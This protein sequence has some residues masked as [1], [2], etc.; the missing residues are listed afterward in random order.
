MK[1]DE[2]QAWFDAVSELLFREPPPSWFY[3]VAGIF[4][5]VTCLVI[6]F[7]SLVGAWGK[8]RTGYIS[9]IKP[10]ILDED[11]EYQINQ[12]RFFA[13]Y[14]R[15]QLERLNEQ[16]SWSDRRYSELEVEAEVEAKGRWHNR[17]LRTITQVATMRR[18]KLTPALR[19]SAERLILLQGDPGSGKSV[20]LRHIAFQMVDEAIEARKADAVLPIYIN[21]KSLNRTS[22]NIDGL[23]I[24]QYVLGQVRA[25]SRDIDIERYLEAEFDAGLRKGTWMFLLDSFDEVPEIL[26]STDSDG[27]VGE[28]TR[29]IYEFLRTMNTCR[30]VVASRLFRGP[31]ATRWAHFRILPM[32]EIRQRNLIANANLPPHKYQHLMEWIKNIDAGVQRDLKTQ[33]FSESSANMPERQTHCPTTH[34]WCMMA[35]LQHDSIETPI[36]RSKITDVTQPQLAS[37]QKSWRYA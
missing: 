22:P 26:A 32:D 25:G 1:P 8:I 10:L 14:L 27:P 9:H 19:H 36:A 12:R 28:Y 3:L 18:S 31:R 11:M 23:A 24:K 35:I 20:A 29:A 7:A 13:E 16:E 2:L 6:V 34:T 21:L 15:L 5:S 4:M 37:L 30:G 17:F 33:C